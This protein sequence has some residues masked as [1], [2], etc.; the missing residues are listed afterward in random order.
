[1][2]NKKSIL[3][4]S[5]LA[6]ALLAVAGINANASSLIR[7]QQVTT[8]DEVVAGV[9]AQNAVSNSFEMKCGATKKSDTT[10]TKKK[11]KDGKCGEGKC[12]STKKSGN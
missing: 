10:K 2:E 1:M 6:G 3:A 4:G 5:I 9:H 8:P 7:Y 12:G 11:G